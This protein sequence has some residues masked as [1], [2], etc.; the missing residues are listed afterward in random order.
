MNVHILVREVHLIVL[1]NETEKVHRAVVIDYDHILELAE[2][3]LRFKV[4]DRV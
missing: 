1:G 2:D 4:G 3:N